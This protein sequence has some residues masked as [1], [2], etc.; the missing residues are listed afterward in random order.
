MEPYIQEFEVLP[1][2]ALPSTHVP[3]TVEM[4]AL[5]G[6][7]FLNIMQYFRGEELFLAFIRQLRE[8]GIDY[9]VLNVSEAR[10]PMMELPF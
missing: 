3:L 10:W 1:S 6:Y 7:F 9:D 4:S 2:T 5:H 8:N